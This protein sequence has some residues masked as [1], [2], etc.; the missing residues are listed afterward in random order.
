[1]SG[2][3]ILTCF[4]ILRVLLWDYYILAN[5]LLYFYNIVI[6]KRLV[7]LYSYSMFSRDVRLA[8]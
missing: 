5:I 8:N 7:S 6:D 3:T 4:W 2:M 1:M